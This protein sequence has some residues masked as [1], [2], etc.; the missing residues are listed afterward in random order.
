MFHRGCGGNENKFSTVAECQE[1]CNRRKN[2]TQ[3]SKGNE[4]LV[5]FECQLRTD[6]KIPEKAQKC[7]DGCPIGYRCNE[8]NK[9]C[10]MKSMF[11]DF[12]S[13]FP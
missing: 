9:C 13:L 10:P 1:K 8:N 7:D 11:I 4:G 3:P 5:V 2:V 6:A 12:V